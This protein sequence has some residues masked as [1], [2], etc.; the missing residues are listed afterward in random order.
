M[1]PMYDSYIVVGGVEDDT[2]SGVENADAVDETG[3][4]NGDMVD[5][6]SMTE[7]GIETTVGLG[8]ETSA[9]DDPK[10]EDELAGKVDNEP[11]KSCMNAM[12]CS[13]EVNVTEIVIVNPLCRF[14]ERG[15]A[16]GGLFME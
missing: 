11:K 15:A 14:R 10:A 12:A 3:V 16:T 6:D 5:V 8:V 2:T 1:A 13:A 7:V 4:E 9:E